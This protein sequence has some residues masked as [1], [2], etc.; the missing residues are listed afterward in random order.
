[1][2]RV[3]LLGLSISGDSPL[4]IYGGRVTEKTQVTKE[5]IVSTVVRNLVLVS[6]SQGSDRIHGG[7]HSPSSRG[8]K[9]RGDL[10]LPG[11]R[12]PRRAEPSSQ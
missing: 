11:E 4:F 3:L 6:G 10:L 1:M 9:R 7:M 5:K 8:A 2:L 12:L